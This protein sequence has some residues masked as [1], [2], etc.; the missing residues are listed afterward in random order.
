M[1]R[2]KGLDARSISMTMTVSCR[3]GVSLLKMLVGRVSVRAQCTTSC[4]HDDDGKLQVRGTSDGLKT[5]DVGIH[6][7]SRQG[8]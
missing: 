1:G 3:S 8:Q 2:S 4:K 5:L 6:G 7:R